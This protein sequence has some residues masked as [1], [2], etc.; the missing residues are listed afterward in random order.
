MDS[1][2]SPS[3]LQLPDPASSAQQLS[4]G[5]RLLNQAQMVMS[6]EIQMQP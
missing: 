6:T 2:L 3:S 1:C 4:A 5:L